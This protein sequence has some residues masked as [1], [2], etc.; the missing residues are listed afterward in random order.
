MPEERWQKEEEHFAQVS[1]RNKP[2]SA[3]NSPLFIVTGLRV[4]QLVV[5]HSVFSGQNSR[6]QKEC[7][8]E[9][10][11]SNRK[12]WY[13][14]SFDVNHCSVFVIRGNWVPTIERISINQE[15]WKLGFFFLTP[16]IWFALKCWTTHNMNVHDYE[17][18]KERCRCWP[19]MHKEIKLLAVVPR[20]KER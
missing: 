9:M 13:L 19:G 5:R 15:C 8:E 11:H 1:P 2:G 3:G 18:A 12:P 4:N 7:R 6:S 20:Q 17:T 14:F 10:H 16:F